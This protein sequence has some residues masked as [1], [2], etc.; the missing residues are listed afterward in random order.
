VSNASFPSGRRIFVTAVNAN[1]FGRVDVLISA[2]SNS[3]MEIRWVSGG[4][5]KGWVSLDNIRYS[6]GVH[7]AASFLN[8]WAN[9]GAPYQGA[10]Y[11]ADG[12][13]VYVAGLVKHTAIPLNKPVFFLPATHRPSYREIFASSSNN[14]YARVDVLPAGNVTVVAATGTTGWVSL[15]NVKFRPASAT[16]ENVTTSSAWSTYPGY[17]PMSSSLGDDGFVLLRGLVRSGT[18]API[19]TLPVSHRPVAQRIFLTACN[20]GACRVDVATTGVVSV[21]GRTPGTTTW[22]SWVSLSGISF[23]PTP[24]S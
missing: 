3:N 4:A 14:G 13:A 16:F 18:A 10:S 24:G 2:G 5:G 8:G 17:A 7:S 19:G 1:V 23:D 9:Y 21:V 12:G 20:F 15:S 22:P 6:K 11:I